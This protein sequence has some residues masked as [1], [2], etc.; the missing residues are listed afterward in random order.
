[1]AALDRGGI[2][3]AIYTID[4]C[5]LTYE[6]NGGVNKRRRHLDLK[7]FRCSYIKFL[8]YDFAVRILLKANAQTRTVRSHQ[9]CM[10]I[11]I[12]LLLLVSLVF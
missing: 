1:M 8:F 5:T 11:R 3:K 10:V 4:K 12:L 7:E 6:T 9:Y 2:I